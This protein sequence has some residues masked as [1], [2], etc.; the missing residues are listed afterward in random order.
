MILMLLLFGKGKHGLLKREAASK[1]IA[2]KKAKNE[3]R[4]CHSVI[5]VNCHKT[6]LRL[7]LIQYKLLTVKG[8]WNP[9]VDPPSTPCAGSIITFYVVNFDKGPVRV[10]R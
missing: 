10:K 4:G 2:H 8:F 3:E 9:K 6:L 7:L 1:K 5:F